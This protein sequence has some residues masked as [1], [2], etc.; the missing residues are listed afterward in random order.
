MLLAVLE[1]RAGL[2]L[3]MHDVFA[4]IAGGLK[5]EEP[6]V[7]LGIAAAVASAF[8][9]KNADPD[10]AVVGEIGLGGEI[11]SVSQLDKRINEAQKLGFKRMIIPAHNQR[12]A[13]NSKIQLIE[14]RFLSEALQALI[15]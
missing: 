14:V 6:A 11:R 13:G 3:G 10:T 5:L 12:T 15:A 9:N 4:N 8:R 2:N 1:R 7:D